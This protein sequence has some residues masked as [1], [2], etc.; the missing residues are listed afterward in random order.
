MGP[1]VMSPHTTTDGVVTD[2]TTLES[3]LRKRR[4]NHVMKSAN[5]GLAR[6]M[7]AARTKVL[8]MSAAKRRF[9]EQLDVEEE[10][11]IKA[12]PI[13][14]FFLR[15]GKV[16]AIL[17][18]TLGMFLGAYICAMLMESCGITAPLPSTNSFS[19]KCRVIY[20]FATQKC[21]IAHLHLADAISG[22]L[23]EMPWSSGAARSW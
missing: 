9:S 21:N 23:P 6:K 16:K 20:K 7:V 1:S 12:Y 8:Y 14:Y 13:K 3:M 22:C 11:E 19:G 2:T 17:L 15:M 4:F 18:L 5:V 10:Y